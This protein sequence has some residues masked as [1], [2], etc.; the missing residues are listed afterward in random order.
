MELAKLRDEFDVVGDVRGKGLMIGVELVADK[1][2]SRQRNAI[3]R[4]LQDSA[5]YLQTTRAPL[6]VERVNAIW[7]GCKDMGLLLG[8]GGLYGST[9]RIKPPMCITKADVDF[10]IDVMRA[11]LARS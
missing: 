9:L 11:Q 1:V 4:F 8:K 6:P 7:E 2:A 3:S 10:S 5:L